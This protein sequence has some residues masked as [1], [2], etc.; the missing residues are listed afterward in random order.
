MASL[1]KTVS[2]KKSHAHLGDNIWTGIEKVVGLEREIRS[3]CQKK[4]CNRSAK[5]VGVRGIENFFLH[6]IFGSLQK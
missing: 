6:K 3:R 2:S 4:V 5:N 1:K